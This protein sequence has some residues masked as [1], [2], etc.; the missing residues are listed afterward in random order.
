MKTAIEVKA[1][2][3][4]FIA[5]ANENVTY[6]HDV[7]SKKEVDQI[8]NDLSAKIFALEIDQEEDNT[9]YSITV[10]KEAIDQMFGDWNFD[11]YI[12]V[13]VDRNRTIE[14]DFDE[15]TFR[16]DAVANIAANLED[17]NQ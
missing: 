9:L 10:I 8:L 12:N 16:R 1:A 15:R 11:E 5:E 3:M 7:Y 4:K 13:S 17:E 2:L 14:I 6:G